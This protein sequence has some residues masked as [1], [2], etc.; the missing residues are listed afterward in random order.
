MQSEEKGGAM[1]AS[2]HGLTGSSLVSALLPVYHR[3]IPPVLAVL[4]QTPP[5]LRLREVGMNC[6]CEY[7]RFPRFRKIGPYSRYDHSLGVG[8]IVWHFTGDAAQA[9]AGLLH[10][11]ATPVFAHVVDFLYGDHL[12]QTTTEARTEELIRRSP[13]LLAALSAL[14]L[15]VEQVAD[16]H[17]YPIADNDTPR[18]SADRLEYTLGNLVNYGFLS[19]REAAAFY[20]DLAVDFNEDGA[21]ELS[22]RTP[23]TAA[24]F[25]LAALQTSRVYVADEDRFSMQVLADLLR[26]ALR[27]GVLTAEALIG[28]EPSVIRKLLDDPVCGPLWQ[29]FCAY[30]HISSVPAKPPRGQWLQVPAKL[31]FIDPLAQGRGRVSSWSPF[32]AAA[33]GGISPHCI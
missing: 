13:E 24:A 6:G 27:R 5:L 9:A 28:T 16:H 26:V 25:A 23:E 29:R 11:A 21:Q 3:E 20:G 19:L 22:F 10:D 31:R 2:K 12:H 30:E 4:A 33:A 18:L 32:R 14:D 15:T 1:M 17:R 8:L 7:T